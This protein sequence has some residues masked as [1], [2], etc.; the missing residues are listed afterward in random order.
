MKVISTKISV[1]STALVNQDIE[2]PWTETQ[3]ALAKEAV[4]NF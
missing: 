1:T 4:L 2:L 3:T